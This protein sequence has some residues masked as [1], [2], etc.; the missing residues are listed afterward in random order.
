MAALFYCIVYDT[1]I[2]AGAVILM[3]AL[4][5]IVLFN[6]DE[7]M[8]KEAGIAIMIFTGLLLLLM[9]LVAGVWPSKDSG[10]SL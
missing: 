3:V 1:M 6:G 5:K 10:W 7:E 9:I 2:I 8:S 4:A